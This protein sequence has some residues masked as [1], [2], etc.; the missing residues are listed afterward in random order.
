VKNESD[1]TTNRLTDIQLVIERLAR[2]EISEENAQ[3]VL[4]KIWE[5][6]YHEPLLRKIVLE[7]FPSLARPKKKEASASA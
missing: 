1:L 3:A 4:E 7:L 5:E 6:A 2:K